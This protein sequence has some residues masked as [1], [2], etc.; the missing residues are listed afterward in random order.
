VGRY[1]T[2][3]KTGAFRLRLLDFHLINVG[4][5]AAAVAATFAAFLAFATFG[6]PADLAAFFA[7]LALPLPLA[8]FLAGTWETPV[9]YSSRQKTQYAL[10]ISSRL[11]SSALSAIQWSNSRLPGAY[12]STTSSTY[13][14]SCSSS[15]RVWQSIWL[16]P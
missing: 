11:V 14:L 13:C 6:L 5:Y 4:S 10:W 1:K 7:G 9:V 15:R 12:F 8:A 2:Q 16:L 3:R